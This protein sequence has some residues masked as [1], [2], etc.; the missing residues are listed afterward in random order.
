[1]DHLLLA[2]RCRNCGQETPRS[3]GQIR[4]NEP[5]ACSDCGEPVDS[6]GRKFDA[7]LRELERVRRSRYH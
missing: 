1:M 4:T 5:F 2:V 3:V 6:K 7:R